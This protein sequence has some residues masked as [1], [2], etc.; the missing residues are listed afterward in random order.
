[1]CGQGI[2]LSEGQVN[3]AYL[4]A[5]AA[6]AGAIIGGL[7]SFCTSWVTQR[8]QLRHTRRET[9]RAKLETLYNDF[10]AEATRLLGDALTRQTEDVTDMVR[11]Y[12]M[13]GRMR[14]I[15][16]RAVIDAAVDMEDTILERYLGANL[17]LQQVQDYA[18]GEG[19]NFLT[20]FSE[21]CRKDLADR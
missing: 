4:S 17:T 2:P 15:S 5:V 7:A 12:A 18:H 9:E 20:A 6:L 10:I 13:I 14:L 19:R 11:L 3:P 8:T 1:M 16:D 21:A